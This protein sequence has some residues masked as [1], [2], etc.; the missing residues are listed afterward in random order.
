LTR[1]AI[2]HQAGA[3]SQ[4]SG[5]FSAIAVA[6]TMLLFAPAARYIPRAALAGILI[7]T[8]F[9]MVDWPRLMYHLRATRFDAVITLATAISAVAVSVEHCIM[10]GTFL[11]FVFYVPK[12]ARLQMI[13]LVITPDRLIRERL[14]SDPV[15]DRWR[16]FNF[17]GELF[18]GSGPE[19]ERSLS[20]IENQA[21]HRMRVVLIRLKYSRNLDAVCLELLE[22]FVHRMNGRGII[23][24]FCGVSPEAMQTL[25]N[26]GLT[27]R[28]GP[29][30]VFPEAAAV[31]SSTRDAVQFAY[32]LLDKDLCDTCPRR[33]PNSNHPGAIYYEI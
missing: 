14:P 4:W 7:V 23:V 11:S 15:C 27:E 31:W 19:L 2:N 10:I 9:R 33:L 30:R 26:V 13:E 8:A 29:R 32:E 18:F 17:E 3:V 16:L 6:I 24:L 28:L 1:S 20:E 5:V 22:A 12:A 25:E 21:T